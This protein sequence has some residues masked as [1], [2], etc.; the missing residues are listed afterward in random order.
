MKSLIC[1]S[2]CTYPFDVY[3]A[4]KLHN[5]YKVGIFKLVF[6]FSVCRFSFKIGIDFQCINAYEVRNL[7]VSSGFVTFAVTLLP[8]I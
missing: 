6:F 1:F 2:R 7:N 3:F 8:Y 4:I 5:C